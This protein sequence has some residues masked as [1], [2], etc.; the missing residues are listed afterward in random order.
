MFRKQQ[1]REHRTQMFLQHLNT[2]VF[3]LYEA[4]AT[5]ALAAMM[6]LQNADSALNRAGACRPSRGATPQLIR[7]VAP[8]TPAAAL[9]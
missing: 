9:S 1:S 4:E 8:P 6:K 3:V 5:P 2:H 7:A